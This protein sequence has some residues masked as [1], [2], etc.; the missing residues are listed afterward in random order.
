MFCSY[1]K[2]NKKKIRKRKRKWEKKKKKKK[3]IEKEKEESK[4]TMEGLLVISVRDLRLTGGV[5]PPADKDN[6]DGDN[7]DDDD[8]G[9]DDGDDERNG[10]VLL[11]LLLMLL[12]EVLRGLDE[13]GAGAAKRRAL[14]A[15]S[16]GSSLSSLLV[17]PLIFIVYFVGIDTILFPVLM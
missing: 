10:F 17:L 16:F 13:R 7:D 8:V 2:T 3:K 12:L 15:V 9:D 1:R 5:D 14:I 6:G 11:E 4:N